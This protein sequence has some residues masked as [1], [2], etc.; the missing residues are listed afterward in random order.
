MKFQHNTFKGNGV[1]LRTKFILL[2]LLLLFLSK[3]NNTAKRRSRVMNPTLYP[4]HCHLSTI[5]ISSRYFVQ[6][7]SFSPDKNDSKINFEGQ[8]LCTWTRKSTLLLITICLPLKFQDITLHGYG[9]TR[10]TNV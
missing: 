4:C 3:G 5:E 6:S 1:K 9:D 10:R 8:Q 7:R 2:L